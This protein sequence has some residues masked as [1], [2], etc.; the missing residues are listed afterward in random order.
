MRLLIV[1]LVLLVGA[2]PGFATVDPDPD[3]IGIYFD[4]NADVTCIDTVPFL[5]FWAY[6]MVTNPTNPEIWGVEFSLCVEVFGGTEDML[7]RLSEQWEGGSSSIPP[8]DIDWCA[9]GVMQGFAYPVLPQSGNTLMVS[10]QYMLVSDIAVNFYLGPAANQS[11]PDGLP[12]YLGPGGLVHPLGISS[13]SPDLPVASVNCCF[14]VDSELTT[15]GKL[16]CL[17]R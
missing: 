1:A 14:V 11:I 7:I 8:F 4:Y 16:K 3:Q 9:D 5:P 17:Y 10:L 2:L 15:F 12:A 13:G 6:V